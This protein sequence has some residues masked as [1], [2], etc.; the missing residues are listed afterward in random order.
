MARSWPACPVFCPCQAMRQASC[1]PVL[2][3]FEPELVGDKPLQ[4]MASHEIRGQ[5]R[6]CP[7]KGPGTDNQ[8]V[9]SLHRWL[10]TDE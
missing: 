2:D 10:G 6:V 1:R 8:A 3:T 4:A 9:R 7:R 5:V